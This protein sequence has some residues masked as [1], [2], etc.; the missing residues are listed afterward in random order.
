MDQVEIV[1]V[2][3]IIDTSSNVGNMYDSKEIIRC[4]HSIVKKIR[5]LNCVLD[6]IDVNG[7]EAPDRIG[8]EVQRTKVVKSAI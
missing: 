5:S 8:V 3:Y 4:M 7:V 6:T 1:P 2:F